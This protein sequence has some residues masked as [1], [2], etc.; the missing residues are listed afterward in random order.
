MFPESGIAIVWNHDVTFG[1][2]LP[3]I[4]ECNGYELEN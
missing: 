3:A 2:G 1:L 4:A